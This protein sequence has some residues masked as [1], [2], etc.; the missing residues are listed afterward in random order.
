MSLLERI[1][2][3]PHEKKIRL[4]WICSGVCVIILLIVWAL[5]SRV[6]RDTPRDTS[7]FQTL[8]QGF[9]NFKN[10]RDNPIQ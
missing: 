10:N 2:N 5:A 9:D 3:Q 4:I 1:R 7:I 6:K 8:D